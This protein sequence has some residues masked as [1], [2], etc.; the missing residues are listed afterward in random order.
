MG[1]DTDYVNGGS[2]LAQPVSTSATPSGVVQASTGGGSWWMDAL[3]ELGDAAVSGASS[4]IKRQGEGKQPQQ[5]TDWSMASG[6]NGGGGFPVAWLLI[7]GGVLAVVL[8]LR[9]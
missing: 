7:G 3:T 5:P 8:L 6:G 4:W 1:W 9:D 2:L